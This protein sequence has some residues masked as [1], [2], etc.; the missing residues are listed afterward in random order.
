[1]A[2]EAGEDRTGGAAHCFCAECSFAEEKYFL[3]TNFDG[4]T[5][6][7]SDY[8]LLVVIIEFSMDGFAENVANVS[9]LEHFELNR[10]WDDLHAAVGC[11]AYNFQKGAY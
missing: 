7:V 9:E 2:L 11:A 3:E 6:T 4:I 1:M 5:A 8:H 10:D